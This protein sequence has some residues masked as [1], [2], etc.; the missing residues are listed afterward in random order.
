M[1]PAVRDSGKNF[2]IF[3]AINMAGPGAGESLE[4]VTD[5]LIK[6]EEA[7]DD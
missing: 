3:T 1:I 2:G 5:Y 6:R 4:K 7:L